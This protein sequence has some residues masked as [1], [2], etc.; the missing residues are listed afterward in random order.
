VNRI[1]DGQI[2][3]GLLNQ[4]P[5]TFQNITTIK[6]IFVEKLLSVYHS[7]INYPELV[8]KSVDFSGDAP[9]SRS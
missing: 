2:A 9:I 7:R 4:A 1:I 6:N 8:K 3:D 5:L